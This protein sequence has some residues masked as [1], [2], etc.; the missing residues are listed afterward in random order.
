MEVLDCYIGYF[1]SWTILMFWISKEIYLMFFFLN[2]ALRSGRRGEEPMFS[3][4]VLSS[5]LLCSPPYVSDTYRYRSQPDHLHP[6][7]PPP[8]ARPAPLP[9][10]I[11][12]SETNLTAGN[13][14]CLEIN[15][16]S[17]MT[18][19]SGDSDSH[20]VSQSVPWLQS[21]QPTLLSSVE[22]YKLIIQCRL[23]TGEPTRVF[24]MI[25]SKF[26]LAWQHIVWNSPRCP[27]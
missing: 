23:E 20:W 9:P 5:A 14:N 1:T 21:V 4:S 18:L 16:T 10:P 25:I 3:V 22:M 19:S 6:I 17:R 26:F 8:P 24:M 12:T 27:C 13:L 11:I 15:F 7:I 2:K